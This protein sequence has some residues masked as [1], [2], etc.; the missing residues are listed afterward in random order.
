M[1][2]VRNLVRI[3]SLIRSLP[4]V[5]TPAPDGT[6]RRVRTMS[7]FCSSRAPS[8]CRRLGSSPAC[9]VPETGLSH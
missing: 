2:D 7:V 9:L 3:R 5:R 8:S 6:V 4:Y 1:E